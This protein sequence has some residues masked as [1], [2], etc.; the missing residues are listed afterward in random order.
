[1]GELQACR[2]KS[3]SITAATT[4]QVTRAECATHWPPSSVA[5]D[6]KDSYGQFNVLRH[7]GTGVVRLVS[8]EIRADH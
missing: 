6:L 4:C 2:A 3:S 1:M 5:L 8:T 7:T